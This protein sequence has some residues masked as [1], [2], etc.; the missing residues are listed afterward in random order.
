MSNTLQT[1]QDERRSGQYSI[2]IS[3]FSFEQSVGHSAEMQERERMATEAKHST[4]LPAKDMNFATE[5][6]RSILSDAPRI[7]IAWTGLTYDFFRDLAMQN[8][9]LANCFVR[10][11]SVLKKDTKVWSRAEHKARRR[12]G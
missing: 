11:D 4:A 8:K 6:V 12:R 2:Q 5:G 3:P 10:P 7:G 9:K 1:A